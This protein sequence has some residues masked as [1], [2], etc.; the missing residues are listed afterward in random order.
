[1]YSKKEVLTYHIVFGWGAK[2]IHSEMVREGKY[3]PSRNSIRNFKFQPDT[4]SI[5]ID[6]PDKGDYHFHFE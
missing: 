6:E 5:V 2:K 3:P 4:G 1:M